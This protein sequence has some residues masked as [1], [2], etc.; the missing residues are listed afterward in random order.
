[1]KTTT[2]VVTLIGFSVIWSMLNIFINVK[3]DLKMKEMKEN[4]PE[5]VFRSKENGGNQYVYEMDSIKQI[6]SESTWIN[7]SPGN[8]LILSAFVELSIPFWIRD[9][10]TPTSSF[11]EPITPLPLRTQSPSELI[12]FTYPNVQS[13][14][15]MPKYLPVDRG[16]QIDE[17]GNSI[18]FV[19]VKNDKVL[20]NPFEEAPNC[21]VDADPFLPWIHDVFPGRN[22]DVIHF[23]AQNKRR[24]NTGKHFRTEVERLEPQVSLMQP[25][26]VARVSHSQIPKDLWNDDGNI[27]NESYKKETRWRL[28]TLDEADENGIYTRFIC[29]FKALNPE[30]QIS[31]LGETLSVFPINYE[32]ANKRKAQKSMLTK[33]GKDQGLMWLSSFQFD[34]PVPDIDILQQAI[35][36]EKNIIDNKAIVYVDLVP[37]RTPPRGLDGLHL[38]ESL[39]YTHFDAEN[40]WGKNHVL[41]KIEASGR[42]E[43]IPI[44]SPDMPTQNALPEKQGNLEEYENARDLDSKS[45]S[46][47]VEKKHILV[48]CVW[49]S[50][51]YKT[52]NNGVHVSD[53]E[54]RMLEWLE[55]HLLAGFDHIYVYDNTA[56][57]TDN[58]SDLSK[59]TNLF[60]PKEVT[61]I[62]WP[63]RVCNN[64]FPQ[65]EN[66]GERSSQYAAETS[67]R[68]RYGPETEWMASFDT[69]EYF[70]PNGK[71]S[72][73]KELLMDV[74]EGGTNILSFK[75]ARSYMNI[76]DTM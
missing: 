56:A 69:D 66:S 75:S 5:T 23:V 51:S 65:N 3:F 34:C 18:P 60:S 8:S 42:W 71:Y 50:S 15:D 31:I 47:S 1:M 30:G 29:R 13:C 33:E 37:I 57:H 59:V 72:N 9:D 14:L 32:L 2:A 4:A 26:S 7:K 49:A 28:S 21:P 46:R 12:R 48:G 63:F 44:C 20:E 41:P 74:K 52:R 24:C 43:N 61:H 17:N 19:N 58:E 27:R 67:C 73:L 6:F 53:T 16:R 36:H 64:N 76:E 22:G 10:T 54:E 25:V 45:E 39:G 70:I 68:A 38:P 35:R 62:K 40:R 55:Y 11:G